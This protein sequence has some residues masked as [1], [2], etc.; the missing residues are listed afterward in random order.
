MENDPEQREP[1]LD[2]VLQDDHWRALDQELK[3]AAVGA[4]RRHRQRRRHFRWATGALVFLAV[5]VAA[6]YRP[7]PLLTAHYPR[8]EVQTHPTPASDGVRYLPDDELLKLFPPG[9]CVLL[10]I[11]GRTRLI[12]LD[13]EV[14][15]TYLAPLAVR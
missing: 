2:A 8:P 7:H 11:E 6:L 5:T 4:F 12:F 9:S 15:R 13:P 10:E 1:L 14:E 3:S